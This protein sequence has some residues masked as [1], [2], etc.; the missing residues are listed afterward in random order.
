MRHALHVDDL[1]TPPIV[2]RRYWVP[3]VRA[4]GMLW[5]VIGPQHADADLG[6]PEQHLHCD[7]RFLTDRQVQHNHHV[8]FAAAAAAAVHDAWYTK[9]M[10]D[11]GVTRGD[12]LEFVRRSP[13]AAM[14][15]SSLALP[16]ETL[17]PPTLHLRTCK[18]EAV[19]AGVA[20]FLPQLE[21][22]H[23]ASRAVDC[24]T[25]PHRGAPLSS[26]PV[27]SDGGVVCPAHGLRWSK[28]TGLLMPRPRPANLPSP[29]V[30]RQY[31]ESLRAGAA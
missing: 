11:L 21:R 28:A 8:L 26:L 13:A 5:P 9:E 23:A 20:W 18:R 25:C 14:L 7:A 30:A 16:V 24:R 1:T 12:A 19:A 3:C 27:D 2:G 15:A 29:E 4:K 17:R 31:R 6:V 22:Q 10:Q